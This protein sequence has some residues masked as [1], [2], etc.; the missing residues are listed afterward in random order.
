MDQFVSAQEVL[1]ALSGNFS[2]SNL[3]SLELT[4]SMYIP[5][6]FCM[7]IKRF[8]SLQNQPLES[9]TNLAS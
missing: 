6:K 4:S 7:K 1:G 3:L 9:V 2:V 8:G 5:A